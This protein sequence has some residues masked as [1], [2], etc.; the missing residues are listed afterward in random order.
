MKQTTDL[1]SAQPIKMPEKE[2]LQLLG[3]PEEEIVETVEI[4][5][6][7]QVCI[8]QQCCLRSSEEEVAH[9]LEFQSRV[10]I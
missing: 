6:E 4:S 2:M 8:R 1:D 10:V 7:D 9:P 3:F 5:T